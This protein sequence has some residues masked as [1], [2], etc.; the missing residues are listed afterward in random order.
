MTEQFKK[1]F[2]LA[3][4]E[5]YIKVETQNPSIKITRGV[6]MF[7]RN[8]DG[9]LNLS[10]QAIVILVMAMAVLGLGLGFI[11]GLITK[12][13]ENLG[14]AIENAE[15][16][17]PA[18]AQNIITSDRTVKLKKGKTA[19]MSI[20]FYNEGSSSIS[21]EPEIPNN[22]CVNASGTDVSFNI[23]TPSQNVPA[24]EAIGFKAIL[25]TYGATVG[26]YSCSLNVSGYMEQFTV[27]IS[28]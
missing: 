14:S 16:E 11:R 17:N 12:G 7:Q 4:I 20:G 23:S 5:N 13:E 24:G 18:T 26:T 1:L 10:I 9:S 27:E 3:T 21:V 22:G 2:A 6:F 19:V 25:N 8:K 28:G 15:L